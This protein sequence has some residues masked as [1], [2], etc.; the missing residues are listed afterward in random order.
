MLRIF[1]NE[2]Y[3]IAFVTEVQTQRGR[4]IDIRKEYSLEKST[5]HWYAYV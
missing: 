5:K 2:L 1:H 3:E 4:E